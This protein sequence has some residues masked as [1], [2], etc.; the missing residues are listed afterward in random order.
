MMIFILLLAKIFGIEIRE[1]MDITMRSEER[2][3]RNYGVGH[4]LVSRVVNDLLPAQMME[5]GGKGC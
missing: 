1:I 3:V 5:S 4:V 2:R